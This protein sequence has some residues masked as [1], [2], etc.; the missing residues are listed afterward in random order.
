MHFMHK[1]LNQVLL[2]LVARALECELGELSVTR[3]RVT[4]N[5]NALLVVG[6]YSGRFIMLSDL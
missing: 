4:A 6:G 5:V 1:L 3:L 2:L